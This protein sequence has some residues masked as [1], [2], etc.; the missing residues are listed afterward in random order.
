MAAALPPLPEL[1]NDAILDVYTHVSLGVLGMT[2]NSRYSIIGEAQAKAS[3]AVILFHANPTLT[4]VEI[5]VS[6]VVFL[7]DSYTVYAL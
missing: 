5:L 6:L 3:I 4:Q 7:R 1:P 2:D